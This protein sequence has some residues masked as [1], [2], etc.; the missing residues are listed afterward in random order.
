MKQIVTHSGCSAVITDTN[1]ECEWDVPCIHIDSVETKDLVLKQSQKQPKT[2][3]SAD[4]YVLYSSGSTGKPKGVRGTKEGILNRCNWFQ[5]TFPI[6][7]TDRSLFRNESNAF[8]RIA[9][10][11]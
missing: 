9:E 5:K 8:S 11:H 6:Q 2:T 1:H 7:S 4:I 3:V 10:S